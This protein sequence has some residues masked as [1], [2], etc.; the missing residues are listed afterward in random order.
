MTFEAFEKAKPHLLDRIGIAMRVAL[1]SIAVLLRLGV[2]A[3]GIS[4]IAQ[5][6]V[7]RHTENLCRYLERCKKSRTERGGIL[8]TDTELDATNGSRVWL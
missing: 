6:F 1:I 3:V 2:D 4:M 7:A 5:A 8:G